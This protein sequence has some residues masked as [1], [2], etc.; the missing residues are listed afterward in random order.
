MVTPEFRPARLLANPHLQSILS[1]HRLR[2]WLRRHEA[3]QLE[4]QSEHT[5]LDCGDGVRL[6]GWYSPATATPARGLVVLLHGWEG[7]ARSSYMLN[8]TLALRAAGFAVF[9]LEFRDHGDGQHLNEELFHSGRIAE[10]VGAVGAIARRWPIAPLLVAGY[11]LGGNFALR[12]GLHAP[13][14][15]LDI[16]HIAAVCP[17]IDPANVLHAMESGPWFYHQYFMLKWRRSLRLKQAAFP[18]RYHFDDLL[19]GLNMRQ[20]TEALVLREG[21]FASLA[22]YFDSYAITGERLAH[23]TVPA[24]I[25]T[26]ADDPVIPIGDFRALQLPDST[27]LLVTEHGGHCGFLENWR[28]RSW[29][30]RFIVEASLAATA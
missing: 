9:R 2:R 24:S 16:R 10:V 21:G 18:Q 28:L 30:E 15:G 17:A 22:D 26:A 20:L 8:T 5:L 27:R 7:S 4:A 11:S 23:L 12:V 25:L 6:Q 3:A 13:A 19:R 1:S 14:A 29:A